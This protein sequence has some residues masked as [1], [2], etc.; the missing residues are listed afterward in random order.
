MPFFFYSKLGFYTHDKTS[1][2][3]Y[4]RPIYRHT[5]DKLMKK[6][7]RSIEIFTNLGSSTQQQKRYIYRK[8]ENFDFT[9]NLCASI[10]SI[11]RTPIS[12]LFY[13]CFV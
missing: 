2:I 9:A 11:I 12:I 7:F 1:N 3:I 10:D 8:K 5:T 13:V 6:K 4:V